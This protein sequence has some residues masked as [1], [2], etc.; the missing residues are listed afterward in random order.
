M[1]KTYDHVE[2]DFLEAIIL[3]MGFC[4]NWVKV[5]MR[6]VSSVQFS[7]LINGQPGRSF[8]PSRGLRQG[9]PLSF[10]VFLI[11]SE[12]LSRMIQ[13]AADLGFLDGIQLSMNGLGLPICYLSMTHSLT[14][15]LH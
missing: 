6:C 9:D 1:N 2:W 7:V 10:H 4:E 13:T 11:V 8:R 14:K 12:V 15:K 5:V 3:K